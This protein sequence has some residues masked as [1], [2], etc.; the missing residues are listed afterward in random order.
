[1]IV[2]CD[3][4]ENYCDEMFFF[5]PQTQGFATDMFEFS[6]DNFKLT[7]YHQMDDGLSILLHIQ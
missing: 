3:V 7:D 1:M 5:S 4:M 2:I 6:N